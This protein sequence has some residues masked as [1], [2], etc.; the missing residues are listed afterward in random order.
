MLKQ[1]DLLTIARTLGG[2]PVYGCLPG[3]PA[4]RAGIRYGD[5]LL[6]VDGR[7]TRSWDDYIEIRRHSGASIRV[8]LFRD[9][10]EFEVD[11]ALQRDF[12]SDPTSLAQS[13]GLHPHP[14]D[15]D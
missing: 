2:L 11:L 3:S 15:L 7:A 6:A 10:V 4:D 13:L 8:R 12:A 5:V 1:S 9:G 14:K